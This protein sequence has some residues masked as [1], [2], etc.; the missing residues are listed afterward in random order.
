MP[1]HLPGTL[2][3]FH[4]PSCLVPTPG[5]PSYPFG[6][7]PQAAER[8]LKGC[9]EKTGGA[10][11]PG[12]G[13]A[14]WFPEASMERL[15]SWS[16]GVAC[17][18]PWGLGP[19]C[20]PRV[21]SPTHLAAHL[22]SGRSRPSPPPPE[23]AHFRKTRRG[24]RQGLARASISE[25][26]PA[27]LPSFPFLPLAVLAKRD[28]HGRRNPCSDKPHFTQPTGR[29]AAKTRKRHTVLARE[30]CVRAG[31]CAGPGLAGVGEA[32]RGGGEGGQEGRLG[33][34]IGKGGWEGRPE[35]E[36]GKGDREGRLGKEARGGG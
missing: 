9:E 32:G 29:R 13:R 23:A 10:L 7:H 27:H 15:S 14:Q 4:V 5:S 6:S 16:G 22:A 26:R 17:T 19:L 24:D 18:Q 20:F 3:D 1:L 35:K 36:T 21:R 11:L 25:A 2:G 8:L 34:E 12:L 33:R 28:S 31:G 30:S